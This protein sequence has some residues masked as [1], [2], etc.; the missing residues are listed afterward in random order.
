MCPIH[1]RRSPC[2]PCEWA[3]SGDPTLVAAAADLARRATLGET[4]TPAA[5]GETAATHTRAPNAFAEC[6]ARYKA[7]PD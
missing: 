2:R 1:G 3:G 4:A 7:A 5:L 6:P